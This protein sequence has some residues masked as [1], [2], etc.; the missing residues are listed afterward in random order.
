MPSRRRDLGSAVLDLGSF[1]HNNVRIAATPGERQMPGAKLLELSRMRPNPD[2]PR[3]QFD[4]AALEELADSLRRRG[5]LQPVVVRPDGDG[6]LI[7]MGERRYRA[8]LLAGLE[9]MP[10][11]VREMS[12]EE[13]FLAALT[14]NIQRANLDAGDEAEAYQGLLTRGHSV[15]SI[16]EQLAI[17]PARI[18]KVV[19][20]H[21]DPTLSEAVSS[22]MMTKSEAQE[23]LVAPGEERPRLVQFI[24]GRRKENRAVPMGELRAPVRETKGSVSKRNT[25]GETV[26]IRNTRS[27][28]TDVLED[29]L[30]RLQHHYQ[31]IRSAFE[32]RPLLAWEPVVAEERAATEEMARRVSGQPRSSESVGVEDRR[33]WAHKLR[34]EVEQFRDWGGDEVKDPQTLA[35]LSAVR[36]LLDELLARST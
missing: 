13:V 20:V 30:Q 6:Y 31:E 3:K 4:A 23:L 36:A 1:Q 12:D 8:A 17:S 27:A 10:A 18:S 21:Q 32:V 35:E 14:E 29:P 26:S 9:E 25:D 34:R 22:G 15:R 2:Q 24:A 28:Q 5:V 11:I 16:A 7:V 19:R 33:R